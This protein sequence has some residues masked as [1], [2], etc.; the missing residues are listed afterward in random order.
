VPRIKGKLCNS[1][2]ICAYAP[3]EERNE[4]E[5]N[6]FY[7]HLPRAHET[8]PTSD[9]KL[10]LRDFRAKIEKEEHGCARAIGMYSIHEESS[11]NGLR[12]INCAES[13]N[14]IMER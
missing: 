13:L 2:L 12:L 10:L 6:S 11:E 14:I 8:Y 9:I 5:K 1:S 7:E 3:T 4:A